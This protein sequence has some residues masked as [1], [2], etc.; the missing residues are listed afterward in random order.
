ML[1]AF[2]HEFY[3]SAQ[4]RAGPAAWHRHW[5]VV[6]LYDRD[7]GFCGLI[8][9]DDPADRLLPTPERLQALR[10]FANQAAP[11]RRVRAPARRHAPSRRARPA[12]RAAQP[13]R[14]P[15]GHRRPP[16]GPPR[17]RR[18]SS[19]TST[20]S[21][22]STTRSATRRATR[23]WRIFSALLRECT[24]RGRRRRRGS[25]ARSSRWCCRA[26]ARPTR[27]PS[28]SACAGP[29]RERFADH[30]GDRLRLHRR[31]HERARAAP[32]RRCSCA[33]PTARS[34]PPS[35]SAATAA[36]PRTPRRSRCSTPSARP[37][38]RPASSSPR[39][40][41]WP[42]RSTCATSAPRTPL[43]YR[44][45][46]RGA[47]RAR[48]RLGSGRA[49][50]G[51]APPGSCTTS[52]SSASPTRSST[53]PASSTP[54]SGRRWRATRSS[55][56]GS[57]STPTCTT[58]RA[59][60]SRTTSGSTAPATRAGSPGRRSPLEARILAVADAYEAMTADRPYRRALPAA[61][62]RG[63]LRGRRGDAVRRRGRRR[64]RGDPRPAAR[65][66]A[67]RRARTGCPR[68]GTRAAPAPAPRVR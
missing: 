22:A 6:P 31:R 12:H 38:A 61:V 63:Q 42:R 57:S 17:G 7:G 54:P 43:R 25:A 34:T 67:A 13:S 1:P 26:P 29:S 24:A 14:L 8:W 47:D 46:L 21:S 19:A 39:R 60:C 45:P 28:P 50:R 59:G 66:D 41:C 2:M 44:R 11:R 53:S 49:S 62:A 20:T 18:C 9:A 52:A 56:R 35:T 58:S 16:R 15:R 36:S 51:S 65:P 10:A 5:L 64:L 48:A 4:Q 68:P 23:C 55:A 27:W 30:P 33:R 40:C 37:T 3:P 32:P